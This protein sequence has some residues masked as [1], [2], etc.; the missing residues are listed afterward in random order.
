M[1]EHNSIIEPLLEKVEAYGIS[2]FE[3]IKL[4]SID[5]AAEF[6][7]NVISRFFA[8]LSILM[9]LVIA[10]IGLALWAGELL[11]KLWYG[12]FSVAA[13]YALLGFVL[14]FLAHNWIKR[15][16]SNSFISHIFNI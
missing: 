16:I 7:S 10:S 8:L 2:G 15:S 13:F 9:F 3:L 6:S 4:K 5:K 14:Y 12:F 1:E 11:G